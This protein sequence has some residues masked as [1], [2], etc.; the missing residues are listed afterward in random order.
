MTVTTA[1]VPQGGRIL[2][3]TMLAA[4]TA[5]LWGAASLPPLEQSFWGAGRSGFPVALRKQE[6]LEDGAS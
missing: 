4:Q 3:G 6:R 2:E 1:E 5:F